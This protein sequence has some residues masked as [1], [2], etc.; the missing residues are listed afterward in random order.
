MQSNKEYNIHLNAEITFK[1]SCFLPV[2]T[3]QHCCQ[4]R[5]L[6]VKNLLPSYLVVE[7]SA[8]ALLDFKVSS[9]AHAHT[10]MRGRG[11]NGGRFQGRRK[12]KEKCFRFVVVKLVLIFGHPWFY[13]V[14]A[15]IEFFGEAGHFT[16][17]SGFLELCIIREKLMIYRVVNC[18]I[19]EICSV[20]DEDN[21][22]QY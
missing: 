8:E 21:G 9:T 13:V 3:A 15:C 11:G 14:C 2:N 17:R 10:R 19:G 16:E 7:V 1:R 18:N 4:I 6:R 20:Q 5:C 12:A 22:P